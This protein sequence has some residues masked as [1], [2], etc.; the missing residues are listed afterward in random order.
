MNS[1]FDAGVAI[2]GKESP[3]ITWPIWVSTEQ[4]VL[5]AKHAENRFRY[6]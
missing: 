2:L 6:A 3:S 5:A 4:T 1:L